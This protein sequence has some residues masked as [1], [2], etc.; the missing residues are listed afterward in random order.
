MDKKKFTFRNRVNGYGVYLKLYVLKLKDEH[1]NVRD[2]IR[3]IIT[4]LEQEEVVKLSS[5]SRIAMD[6]QLSIPKIDDKDN[7]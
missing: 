5:Y 6:K 1:M 2:L 4:N 7:K 3:D